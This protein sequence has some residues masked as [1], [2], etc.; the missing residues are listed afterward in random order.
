MTRQV[1]KR[2]LT[3]LL[4]VVICVLWLIPAADPRGHTA[5]A[6][7]LANG[8]V[9]S[10]DFKGAG[11]TQIASLF[12]PAD[13][14]GVR[15]SVLDRTSPEDKFTAN[16]WY[17]SGE[18]TLD[19]GRMKV[20]ATDVNSDGKTDIVAL[21]DDGGTSVRILVWLSNGTSFV[22]QGPQGWW[23]S[24]S[25]AWSRTKALL[26]G[27]F[28]TS[29]RSGLLSI[30]QYDNF[31]MRIH[32]F[33][34]DGKQ[35]VYG[36]N[37]GV[38]DSGVGQYDTARAR[39]AV[40]HFTRPDGPDQVAS[41]YQYPNL[42]IGVHVFTPTPSGLQPVNGW[43]GVWQSSEG[44][45]DLSR[46]KIVAVDYDGDHL[47][48]LLSFY[49]YDNGSVRVHAFN[50]TKSLAFTSPFGIAVFAPFSMPWL[51]T[52]LVAGDWNKDGFGDLATLTSLD[53]GSTHV[54][55]LRSNAEFVGAPRTLAWSF[56]AWVTPAA[57]LAN[58]ACTEC[59]PLTG[60]PTASGSP[61]TRR[62]LAVKIDNAPTGRPHHGISQADMV[63]ELLVEGNIT[64]LAAYFH[65]QDAAEIG[66]VR[67]VRFSDRYTTPMVR[68]V[69]VFS[70]GSQLMMDLVYA[71]MANG[72]YVGVSPQ[73]GEGNSFYRSGVDGKVIP[74]NLF[75]STAALRTAANGVGGA[76]PV[77]VPRWGFLKTV[78]HAPTA[79]GFLGARTAITLN[80]PYRVDAAVRYDYDPSTKTYARY[81][82]DGNSYQREV[83]GAN[84]VAI[85][86]RNIV[87][88]NTDVWA[89]EV[90]DDAG[91][92]QSLDMRLVGTGHASI[93]RDGRR[94]EATWY[95]SSWFDPFTFYTDQGEKVLLSPGQ[96]WTHILPVD[97]AVPSN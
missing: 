67:S 90:R 84:G 70:G 77:N 78:D 19:L 55:V 21:Y 59:W 5:S 41:I 56:D 94:Q 53:D 34:S 10:G 80:I 85:A 4:T 6:Q 24:D 25:Y 1:T 50:A 64:R 71:D 37:Q 54:G 40:G 20:A 97:W 75:T 51:Q 32:S 15:I 93:F 7:T 31:D 48:D 23:R 60:M 12:D 61:V 76:A 9:V 89:T 18:N 66:A 91:G 13:N 86:A 29:G 45:Y 43:A 72:N 46:A 44:A 27:T 26:A 73:L 22:Y 79:G 42:K 36:G 87:V 30:Y 88:I 8:L 81:Q 65:S 96:T 68:G 92:A 62:P 74:H 39:F 14:L 38:F 63:V 11:Y 95:R 57:E 69:L 33:E 83:D 35:F 52:Q 58:A 82:S 17:Q 28:S 47:T 2:L 49:W 16:P 3:V